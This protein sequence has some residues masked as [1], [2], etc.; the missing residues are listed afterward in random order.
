MGFSYVAFEDRFRGSFDVV[1]EEQQK[2]VPF[3]V[4]APGPVVDLGCGR[5]EFLDLMREAG[6]G[7]WGVDTHSEMRAACR[8]RGLDVRDED[9]IA[10]L[11]SLEPASI[12]GLFMSHVVEHLPRRDVL[13]FGELAG[14]RLRPHGVVVVETLNP[15]CVFAHAPFTMDLT[16]EWPIHP[17]TLQFILE[18]NGFGEFETLYRQYLPPDMLQLVDTGVAAATPF[19]RTVLDALQKLQTVVDLSFKNFIYALA[20]KRA[21]ASNT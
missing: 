1:R 5:G 19:E 10:H 14:S 18:A 6:V 20:A 16:H 2:Y 4:D 8:S 21:A 11:E 15:A 7:S 3:F 13:R 12:G 9:V 17:Q